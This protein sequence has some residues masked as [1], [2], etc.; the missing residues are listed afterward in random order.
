MELKERIK[1]FEGLGKSIRSLSEAELDSLIAKASN[2]NSWFTSE[3]VKSALNAWE[4]CLTVTNLEQW[5]APYPLKSVH[6]PKKIGLVMAGNIPLVGLHDLLSVLIMG[7]K[8]HIKLSSQDTALMTFIIQEISNI[9]PEMAADIVQVERMNEIDAVIATGSDNSARYF[10]HYFAQHPHIIRQNRTSVAVIRGNESLLELAEL[11][12]DYF[13]YFGLGCRNVSKVYV[14]KG[15]DLVSLIDALSGF[16]KV[17]DH[18]KYRNNYDYN[19]SIYLVNKETHLDSGF[20]LMKESSELVSPISVL[21][22][23]HYDSEAELSL[24]LSANSDKI[25]CIVSANGWYEGSIPL[26]QAQSPDLWDY[27][28]GVDTIEFLKEL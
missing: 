20:F 16:E 13:Q 14:P 2:N 11:G 12:K 21:F 28:D 6:N 1:V 15:Y 8:A 4:N 22:Y 10:K 19:K 26:G 17:L 7:H 18:H 24:T 3:S 25:Q 9:S 23:E 5:L 27:A